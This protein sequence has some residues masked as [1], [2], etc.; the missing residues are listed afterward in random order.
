MPARRPGPRPSSRFVTRTAFAVIVLFVLLQVVWWIVF[1]RAYV[2]RVSEERL[3]DWRADARAAQIALDAA[4]DEAA[5]REQLLEA[6]PQLAFED[7]AFRVDPAVAA[8]FLERQRGHRRM[9]A[10]EGPFFVLVVLSMLALIGRSLREERSLKRSQQNFLS[11]VTHEFK[12]PVATLR[13]LVQTAQLRDLPSAKRRDYLD[14]MAS[15]IDRLER[16]SEQ[17]L[18]AARL[19][20]APVPVRLDA[21]DLNEVVERLVAAMRPGLEARGAVLRVEAEAGPL[22]VSLDEDAFSLVLGNLL[23]N[24]VKYGPAEGSKP[25]AVRLEGRGDVVMLHVDDGGEGVPEAERERIF[26][27]F[28]RAGDESTRR[29]AGVGLG[30]HLVRSTVQAMNGWIRVGDAPGGRG[31]RF[32]VVLPRRVGR[33]LPAVAPRDGRAGAAS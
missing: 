23:D 30:L 29:A 4:E 13:L 15:E 7:G 10:W 20:N 1:Q 31:G 12:T 16:T 26:G 21:V 27:R 18:A 17:V 14:R 9:F 2:G 3:A 5:L 8:A 19:E 32:T 24:A 6:Q 11:A 22:P 25:V 33:D 28:Y